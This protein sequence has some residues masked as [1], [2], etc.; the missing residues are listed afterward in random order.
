MGCY[1]LSV[2]T[3]HQG[4]AGVIRCLSSGLSLSLST[5]LRLWLKRWHRHQMVHGTALP[6]VR[7]DFSLSKPSASPVPIARRIVLYPL[8]S[9]APR[10]FA[11]AVHPYMTD[12]TPGISCL[13]S[14]KSCSAVFRTYAE[15]TKSC[16]RSVVDHHPVMVAASHPSRS[17]QSECPSCC[18]C[19]I[20]MVISYCWRMLLV[21]G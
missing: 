11:S 20:A 18:S 9:D 4:H 14:C 15:A 3:P 2:P 6:R 16:I 12:C 10:G 7:G 19:A 21:W 13:G 17:T 5:S 1:Q 8:A